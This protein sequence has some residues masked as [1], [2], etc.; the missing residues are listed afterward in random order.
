[1]ALMYTKAPTIIPTS[2][3]AIYEKVPGSKYAKRMVGLKIVKTVR[4]YNN[5]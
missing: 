1:M 2:N 3:E 4:K 5:L